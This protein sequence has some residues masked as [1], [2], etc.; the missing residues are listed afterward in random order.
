MVDLRN[1]TL[2][3]CGV[4]LRRYM[5]QPSGVRQLDNTVDEETGMQSLDGCWTIHQDPPSYWSNLIS[6]VRP[7]RALAGH[8]RPAAGYIARA[9]LTPTSLSCLYEIRATAMKRM[10]RT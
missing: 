8:V 2:P 4:L 9:M 6:C 5:G 1:L 3:E 10:W 7:C